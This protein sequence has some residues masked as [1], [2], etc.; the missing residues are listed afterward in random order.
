MLELKNIFG[1]S[2]DVVFSEKSNAKSKVSTSF[3]LCGGAEKR[4]KI[5]H[6]MVD[7][8]WKFDQLTSSNSKLL[9]FEAQY[10]GYL[11]RQFGAKESDIVLHKVTKGS[12][13]AWLSVSQDNFLVKNFSF[14]QSQDLC[15]KPFF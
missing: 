13:V 1:Q 8:A 10:K 9:D 5:K 12:T 14:T 15:V 2:G 4:L 11:A 7:S 3:I 6:R